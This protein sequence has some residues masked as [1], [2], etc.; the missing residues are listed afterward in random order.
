MMIEK[1]T[2][3]ERKPLDEVTVFAHHHAPFFINTSLGIL[4]PKPSFFLNIFED[5]SNIP[6]CEIQGV[7]SWAKGDGYSNRWWCTHINTY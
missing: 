2:M 6:S 5:A 4:G 7:I 3:T 1:D